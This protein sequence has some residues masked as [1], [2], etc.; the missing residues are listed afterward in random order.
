M[1][2]VDELAVGDA[3]ASG[4]VDESGGGVRP[5]GVAAEGDGVGGGGDGGVGRREEER[6]FEAVEGSGSA[7]EAAPW[8]CLWSGLAWS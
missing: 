8:V 4:G 1:G 7:V 6:G 2:A 3:V 5:G